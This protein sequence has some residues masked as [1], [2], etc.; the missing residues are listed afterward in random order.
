[1]FELGQD[2][3]VYQEAVPFLTDGFRRDRYKEYRAPPGYRYP[4]SPIRSYGD[5][6]SRCASPAS[7]NRIRSRSDSADGLA[8]HRFAYSRYD[9]YLQVSYSR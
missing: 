3:I 7:P 4:R 5:P 8:L 2:S 9:Y 1:M 6:R